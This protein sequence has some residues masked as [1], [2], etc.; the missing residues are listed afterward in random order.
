MNA[1]FRLTHFVHGIVYFLQCYMFSVTQKR[2]LS[3][4]VET[5]HFSM[6]KTAVPPDSIDIVSDCSNDV[7]F[8]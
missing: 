8:P 7:I 3:R 1:I 2:I 6:K 5:S 4:S